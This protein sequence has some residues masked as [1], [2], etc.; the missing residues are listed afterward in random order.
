MDW[1]GIPGAIVVG[2][3][4]LA[5]ISLL[6][7]S[8]HAVLNFLG[9][10]IPVRRRSSIGNDVV[11]P[12]SLGPDPKPLLEGVERLA[13]QEEREEVNEIIGKPDRLAGDELGRPPL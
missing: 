7:W 9:D 5:L 1:S 10:D 2:V 6:F 12:V 4:S 13:T 3:S 11:G 8:G